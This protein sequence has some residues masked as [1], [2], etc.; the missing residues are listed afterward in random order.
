MYYKEEY[1]ELYAEMEDVELNDFFWFERDTIA[2]WLG[3]EDYD[4]LMKD[5]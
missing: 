2:E 5:R 1:D 3:Y 4:E